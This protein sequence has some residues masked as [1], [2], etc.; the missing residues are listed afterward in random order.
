MQQLDQRLS[1]ADD[2]LLGDGGGGKLALGRSVCSCESFFW[3][4]EKFHHFKGSDDSE[5]NNGDANEDKILRLMLYR[6]GVMFFSDLW[7]MRIIF[8][9]RNSYVVKYSLHDLWCEFFTSWDSGCRIS[10]D[11]EAPEKPRPAMPS[12]PQAWSKVKKYATGKVK[13]SDSLTELSNPKDIYRSPW[14]NVLSAEMTAM[15]KSERFAGVQES[16]VCCLSIISL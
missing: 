7:K 12:R 14:W 2:G 15:N 5:V 11:T 4:L 10:W 16:D 9:N 8:T 13:I 6:V 1:L 3:F